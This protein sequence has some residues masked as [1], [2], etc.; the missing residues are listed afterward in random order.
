M[1][2]EWIV[3]DVW[4]LGDWEKLQFYDFKAVR[5]IVRHCVA[6]SFLKFRAAVA[7]AV[8]RFKQMTFRL[9]QTK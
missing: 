5:R 6:R 4:Q 8:A 3:R 2:F 1:K 9:I 7:A